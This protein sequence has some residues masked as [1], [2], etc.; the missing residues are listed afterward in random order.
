MLG[1]LGGCGVWQEPFFGVILSLRDNI[2]NQGRVASPNFV[3]GEPNG[4]LGSRLIL[5]AFPE[6]SAVLLVRDPRDVVASLLDLAKPGGWYNYDRYEI[7]AATA[8]FDAETGSFTFPQP[9]TAEEQIGHLSRDVA[10]S[11]EASREAFDAHD[12]RKV[13][14]KYEDLRTNTLGTMRE[15]CSALELAADEDQLTQAVEKHS[16]KNIPEDKKGQGKP[17]R[18]A[19]PGSWKEDLTPEQVKVVERITAPLLMEFYPE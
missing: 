11:F 7:S 10:A 9:L 19:T 6:S 14:I 3:L 2:A 5:E 17:R 1:D 8:Q 18:K 4:S 16:W 12:G 15:L 13:L